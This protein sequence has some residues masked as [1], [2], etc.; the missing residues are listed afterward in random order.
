[1]PTV[2]NRVRDPRPPT[3]AEEA[4]AAVHAAGHPIRVSAGGGG[5]AVYAARPIRAG[6]I[7]LVER[8]LVLTVAH[9]ARRHYCAMCLADS[10]LQR[11]PMSAWQLRC[12]Q[13]QTQYYCSAACEAAAAARHQ[14]TECSALAVPVGAGRDSAIPRN[15]DYR[16]SCGVPAGHGAAAAST[17]VDHMSTIV[18]GKMPGDYGVRACTCTYLAPAPPHLTAGV[19]SHLTAARTNQAPPKLFAGNSFDTHPQL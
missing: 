3:F 19:Q 10:R 11:P 7:I 17:D 9:G 15:T 6:E 18:S 2:D 8:P 4:T 5:L 16:G 13:C 12:E 1:M 14:G